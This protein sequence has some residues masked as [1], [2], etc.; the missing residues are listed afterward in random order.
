MDERLRLE[1]TRDEPSDEGRYRMETHVEN[2]EWTPLRVQR[3]DQEDNA[4]TTLEE[5]RDVTPLE[6]Y[7]TMKSDDM[8]A[9]EGTGG[10]V[11]ANVD[12]QKAV[13]APKAKLNRLT[14]V[15]NEVEYPC[16]REAASKQ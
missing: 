14:S 13:V 5:V 6:T 16:S 15:L 1:L 10:G 7:R 11:G 2:G 9:Q 3:Y 12:D 8:K 4:W